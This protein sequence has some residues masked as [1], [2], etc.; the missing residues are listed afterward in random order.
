MITGTLT[1]PSIYNEEIAPGVIALSEPTPRPD[2]GPNSMACLANAN[3][4]LCVVELSIRLR[5]NES[6]GLRETRQ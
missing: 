6:Q 2:L 3:G 4:M 1:L 5:S